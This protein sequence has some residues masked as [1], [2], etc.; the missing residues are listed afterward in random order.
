M[1]HI[2]PGIRTYLI[3]L[4]ALNFPSVL[5]LESSLSFIGIGVQPPTATLGQMVGE[6]RNYLMNNPWISV[7]PTIIIVLLSY[8]VQHIGEWLRDEFD[9]RL[10]KS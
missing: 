9:V 5:M 6:G 3:I 4:L 1:K 2:F 7:L 10:D 8:C